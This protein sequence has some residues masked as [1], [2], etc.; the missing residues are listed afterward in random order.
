[1]QG[2]GIVHHRIKQ[3]QVT[4]GSPGAG[5]GSGKT[6]VRRRRLRRRRTPQEQTELW[7]ALAG[8]GVLLI[9][10]GVL[11]RMV[12]HKLYYGAAPHTDDD[13]EPNHQDDYDEGAVQGDVM[14][15]NPLYR[16]PD[17]M[18]I[19]GDRSDHYVKLRRDIDKIYPKSTT[20]SLQ[21]VAHVAEGLGLVQPDVAQSDEL[22]YDIYDCPEYPLPNYPYAWN[23]LAVLEHWP[24]NDVRIPDAIHQGLC[25]FDYNTDYQKAVN[26][27]EAEVPFLVVNDPS[28]AA[29]VERW[30][31]PGYLQSVL[32]DE[33]HRTEYSENNHFMY[34]VPVGHGNKKNGRKKHRKIPEGWTEPTKMLRMRYADFLR[35]ANTTEPVGP[36]DEHWYFRLIGCGTQGDCDKGSSEF[37]Y[38]EL[39]FFQPK[40]N[41]YI[42][43]PSK[44]MGIHCRS[45]MPG[46]IAENHFDGSRNAIVVL[47]GTRRY[48]LSHPEQCGNLA[49]YPKGHPSA[50][51][52]AVDWTN[53]DLTEY[54]LFAN[55]LSNEV[56]LSPGQVLYLPTDWFHF[57][58]SLEMNFQCN[59]RSGISE[60]YLGYMDE[61]GF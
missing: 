25:V 54:P 56:V 10:T 41:L 5:G 24:V 59:T 11:A 20:R 37:L 23:T 7:L 44:Q 16:V 18:D 17:S 31:H 1:M 39:P 61:C 12:Y 14:P 6:P 38:D 49:L 15:W 3:S 50:R 28:V 53:P 47:Q 35:H 27:R 32:G 8:L 42:V 57:I 13:N 51:H 36:D 4:S 45:G 58:V 55:A 9:F 19:V 2:S 48:I 46:V 40:E 21:A 33:A 22:G 43:D 60:N 30:N 34:F 26:Y 52:S 29:A